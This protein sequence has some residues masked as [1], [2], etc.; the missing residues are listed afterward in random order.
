[1]ARLLNLNTLVLRSLLSGMTTTQSLW[2]NSGYTAKLILGKRAYLHFCDITRACFRWLVLKL[3][4]GGHS[5]A[6]KAT[7]ANAASASP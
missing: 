1:M 3:L 4:A 6:P 5:I 7:S 2:R